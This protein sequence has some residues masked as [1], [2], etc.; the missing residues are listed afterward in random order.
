[1]RQKWVE[2]FT[3][4]IIWIS[5]MKQKRLIH[6]AQLKMSKIRNTVMIHLVNHE[7][8]KI[9]SLKCKKSLKKGMRAAVLM[10]GRKK[11]LDSTI[12]LVS[13][14]AMSIILHVVKLCCK[15]ICLS[16][17]TARYTWLL[18]PEPLPFR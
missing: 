5:W 18:Q 9:F 16:S 3:K 6:P 1:M 14:S 15:Q 11:K 4:Y 12:F 17:C 2:V 8:L 10:S 7:W 13:V